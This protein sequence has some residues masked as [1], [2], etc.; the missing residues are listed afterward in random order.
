M[1]LVTSNT[2]LVFTGMKRFRKLGIRRVCFVN[3]H[4]RVCSLILETLTDIDWLPA[5]HPPIRGPVPD[6]LVQENLKSF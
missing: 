1:D 5:A 4:A 2:Y 6:L 3:S